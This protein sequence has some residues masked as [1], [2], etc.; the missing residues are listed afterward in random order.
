MLPSLKSSYEK[1]FQKML[2]EYSRDPSLLTEV[3]SQ[4]VVDDTDR[5][6]NKLTNILKM[7]EFKD[8]V[9]FHLGLQKAHKEISSMH[10]HGDVR[11]WASSWLPKG[12]TALGRLTSFTTGLTNLLRQLP[13][14]TSSVKGS[15]DAERRA[16]WDPNKPLSELL[17][18]DAIDMLTKI[19]VKAMEPPTAFF[20]LSTGLPY[21]ND[22]EA[23]AE[24]LELSYNQLLSLSK[25]GADAEEPITLD[26]IQQLANDLKGLQG[27]EKAEEQPKKPLLRRPPSKTQ[28]IKLDIPLAGKSAR[29][30][31]PI[32]SEEMDNRLEIAYK[33]AAA[34]TFGKSG[35]RSPKLIEFQSELIR[36]ILIDLEMM[37]FITKTNRPIS[38][39]QPKPSPKQTL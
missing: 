38:P 4:Q 13:K 12:F 37:G 17:D 34:E 39:K 18:S 25:M 35:L 33:A 5:R 2:E 14:L 20:Q 29:T 1:N 15:M 11:K 16:A 28:D 21:V 7:P 26:M 36:Q 27:E 30:V 19:A 23:A 32:A 22:K 6:L 9:S 8:L 3:I 24:L 10:T 31:T